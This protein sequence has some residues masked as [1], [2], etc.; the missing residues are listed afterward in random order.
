MPAMSRN[1]ASTWAMVTDSTESRPL[2]FYEVAGG[3]IYKVDE[4]GGRSPIY[5][6]RLP[7]TEEYGYLNIFLDPNY[8]KV[9]TLT[10]DGYITKIDL[11]DRIERPGFINEEVE[12]KALSVP[13]GSGIIKAR[14]GWAGRFQLG[15]PRARAKERNSGLV[16]PASFKGLMK[17]AS[18]TALAPGR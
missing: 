13:G 8:E 9:I 12:P 18:R 7:Q 17:P 3:K 6:T 4:F 1:R 15:K 2:A 10:A 5:Y 14:Q 11:N 16:N